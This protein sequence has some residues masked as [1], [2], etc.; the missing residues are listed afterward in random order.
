MRQGELYV[1]PTPEAVALD[2][3]QQQRGGFDIALQGDPRGLPS[4]ASGQQSAVRSRR[5]SAVVQDLGH[6]AESE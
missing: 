4:V 1:A 2:H 6:L 5:K 3:L